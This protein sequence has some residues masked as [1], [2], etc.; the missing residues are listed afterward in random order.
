MSSNCS[1]SNHPSQE[2]PREKQAICLN[3]FSINNE[4]EITQT[5]DSLWE[6]G[7]VSGV[8]FLSLKNSILL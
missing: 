4:R 1:E 6:L 8:L 3:F 2:T 5:S 7:G